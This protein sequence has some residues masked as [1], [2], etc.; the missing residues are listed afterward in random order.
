MFSLPSSQYDTVTGTHCVFQYYEVFILRGV[1]R[2]K[3]TVTFFV[4]SCRIERADARLRVVFIC[5]HFA[6]DPE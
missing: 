3:R 4:L 5:C 1:Y 2:R 6:R